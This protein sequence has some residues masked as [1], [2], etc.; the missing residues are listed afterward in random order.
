MNVLKRHLRTTIETLL[1]HGVRQ[2]E[3][4][5][6]TGVD[7]KTIRRY[8]AAANSSTPATDSE[9]LA[10]QTPPPRPPGSSGGVWGGRR[11]SIPRIKCTCEDFRCYAFLYYDVLDSQPDATH[12]RCPRSPE[13]TSRVRRHRPASNRYNLAWGNTRSPVRILNSD[14]QLHS[15]LLS[16]HLAS[17]PR[18]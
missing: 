18:C 8:A 5:R 6:R 15:R 17:R 13:C 11:G 16:R 1:E 2:R 3:I 4:E 9:V 14:A 7:R 10:S 12:S